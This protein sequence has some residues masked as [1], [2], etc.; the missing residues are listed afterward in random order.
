MVA[1]V[2]DSKKSKYVLKDG[3]TDEHLWWEVSSMKYTP[4]DVAALPLTSAP[5]RR[6]TAR[7]P[8]GLGRWSGAKL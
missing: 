7:M 3:Q 6:P 1:G 2:H 8:R 4:T 5:S